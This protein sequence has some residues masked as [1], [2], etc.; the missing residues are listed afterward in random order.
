M[1]SQ[2]EVYEEIRQ[3]R[4]KQLRENA[5]DDPILRP[6]LEWRLLTSEQQK[7]KFAEKIIEI[8]QRVTDADQ[9]SARGGSDAN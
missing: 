7:A 5:G 3:E 2:E 9:T 1:K 6:Q 4:I 8:R